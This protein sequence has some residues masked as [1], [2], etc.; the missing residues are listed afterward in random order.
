MRKSLKECEHIDL[1]AGA[2]SYAG[3]GGIRF[4]PGLIDDATAAFVS[5]LP[6]DGFIKLVAGMRE[7]YGHGSDAT[8]VFYSVL[9]GNRK[10]VP[11]LLHVKPS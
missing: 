11:I 5:S 10:R 2:G 9:G 8:E 3:T 1:S 4:E 7:R 6:E